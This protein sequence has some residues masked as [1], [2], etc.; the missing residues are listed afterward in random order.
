MTAMKSHKIYGI[1]KSVCNAEQ[2]IAY[3]YSFTYIDGKPLEYKDHILWCIKESLYRDE[4]MKRF[5][6]DLI[7]HYILNNY[8]KYQAK[9][10][11]ASQYETIG[12]FFESAYPVA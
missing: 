12:T 2:K 8:E 1:D 5:N 10:F 9:P 6:I 11:I 3:N 7:Y 4:K